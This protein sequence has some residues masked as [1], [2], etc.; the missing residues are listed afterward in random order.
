[1]ASIF[2]AVRHFYCLLAIY[3]FSKELHS[4]PTHLPSVERLSI[5]LEAYHTPNCHKGSHARHT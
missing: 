2:K 1:M 5:K 3:A 4:K